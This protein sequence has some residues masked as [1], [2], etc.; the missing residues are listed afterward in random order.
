MSS[1]MIQSTAIAFLESPTMKYPH[2]PM[3]PFLPDRVA[4]IYPEQFSR[5]PDLPFFAP[6]TAENPKTTEPWLMLTIFGVENP[7]VLGPHRSQT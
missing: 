1:G 4:E 2:A 5:V 6:E 3:V 7:R